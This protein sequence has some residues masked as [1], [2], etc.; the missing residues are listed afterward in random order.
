MDCNGTSQIIH[1]REIGLGQSR[2][3]ACKYDGFQVFG[4]FDE[5]P[6]ILQSSWVRADAQCHYMGL[7]LKGPGAATACALR[8]S[9]MTNENIMFVLICCSVV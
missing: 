1:M 5:A 6:V 7:A 8:V 3:R 2:A 4:T 9:F